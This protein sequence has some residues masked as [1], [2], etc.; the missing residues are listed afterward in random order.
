LPQ[1]IHEYH[2][3]ALVM[4][5]SGR[6]EIAMSIMR[7]ACELSR[8]VFRISED[9]SR[10]QIWLDSKKPNVSKETIEFFRKVFRFDTSLKLESEMKNFYDL[11]SD[12][13]THGHISITNQAGSVTN[14]SGRNFV[15]LER[16]ND[17]INESIKMIIICIHYTCLLLLSKFL[18]SSEKH[19]NNAKS[20]FVE[21]ARQM[22]DRFDIVSKFLS[23]KQN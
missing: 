23:K 8:D 20:Q 21:L 18:L 12:F 3:Q 2:Q 16:S 19:D 17:F 9:M 14:I 4:H 15:Q 6:P 13:G 7:L 11:F 10:S 1:T 5:I 22:D